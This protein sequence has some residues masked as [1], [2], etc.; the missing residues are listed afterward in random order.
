MLCCFVPCFLLLVDSLWDISVSQFCWLFFLLQS[1][2]LHLQNFRISNL[3][4]PLWQGLHASYWLFRTFSKSRISLYVLSAPLQWLSNLILL[5]TFSAS[6]CALSSS[7][8]WS[9]L[10]S[11]ALDIYKL[12]LPLEEAWIARVAR[13]QK[14]TTFIVLPLVVL[15]VTILSLLRIQLLI[16]ASKLSQLV[17]VPIETWNNWLLN[18]LILTS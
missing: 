12:Y 18:L 17:F 5:W 10:D 3:A 13:I 15:K 4:S 14:H 16:L 2:V 7:C 8:S 9:W 1:S 11:W 6:H